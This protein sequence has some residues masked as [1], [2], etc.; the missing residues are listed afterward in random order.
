MHCIIIPTKT[1]RCLVHSVDSRWASFTLLS[2]LFLPYNAQLAAGLRLPFIHFFLRA[3]Q[4]VNKSVMKVE[5]EGLKESMGGSCGMDVQWGWCSSTTL[6]Y[7][8]FSISGTFSCILYNNLPRPYV[9]SKVPRFSSR[10]ILYKRPLYLLLNFIFC[11]LKE[12]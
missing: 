10:Y 3:Q 1:I 9:F 8:R 4:L 12:Q 11:L 7:D 2:L 6:W 5:Y